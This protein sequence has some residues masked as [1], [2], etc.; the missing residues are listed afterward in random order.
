[1]RPPENE[2]ESEKIDSLHEAEDRGLLDKPDV[3]DDVKSELN[4]RL[5]RSHEEELD[6]EV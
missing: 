4:E 2:R 5:E 3:P 6:D 1:M